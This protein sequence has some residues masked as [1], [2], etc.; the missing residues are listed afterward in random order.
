MDCCQVLRVPSSL[1]GC[2]F[3]PR[4]D[5]GATGPADS[6]HKLQQ[7]VSTPGSACRACCRWRQSRQARSASAAHCGPAAG[8]GSQAAGPDRGPAA[9]AGSQRAATQVSQAAGLQTPPDGGRVRKAEETKRKGQKRYS[10]FA[11]FN[12]FAFPLWSKKKILCDS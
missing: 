5:E 4:G 8:D 9:T 7:P 11:G 6:Q 10:H 12:F 2:Q 1:Q 3:V